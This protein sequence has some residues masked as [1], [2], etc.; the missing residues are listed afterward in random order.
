M[1]E[2]TGYLAGKLFR[3]DSVITSKL[4]QEREQNQDGHAIDGLFDW[5]KDHNGALSQNKPVCYFS[6]N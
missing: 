3:N 5:Y 6:R 4:K 2:S 1:G